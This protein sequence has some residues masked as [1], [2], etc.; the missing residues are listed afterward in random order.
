MRRAFCLHLHGPRPRFPAAERGRRERERIRG[1]FI[2]RVDRERVDIHP[3]FSRDWKRVVCFALL[4]RDE[5]FG[6]RIEGRGWQ[7]FPGPNTLDPLL[8]A[9]EREKGLKPTCEAKCKAQ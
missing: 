6:L 4:L 9:V 8:L 2:A 5:A 3:V 1:N 7:S